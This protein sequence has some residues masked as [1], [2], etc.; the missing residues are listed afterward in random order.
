MRCHAATASGT[1]A[2]SRIA[3]RR[4]ASGLAATAR[5]DRGVAAREIAVRSASSGWHSRGR[6]RSS[7]VTAAGRPRAAA[8]R[9]AKAR[10]SAGSGQLAVP[11]ELGDLLEA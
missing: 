3:L 8:R 10:P 2:I 1:S 9:A 5:R 11:E 6:V 7:A 4:F